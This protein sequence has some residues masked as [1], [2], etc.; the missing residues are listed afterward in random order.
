[1]KEEMKVL[2]YEKKLRVEGLTGPDEEAELS[3]IKQEQMESD[4]MKKR[5]NL[6]DFEAQVER[7]DKTLN[8]A[9]ISLSRIAYQV[10]KENKQTSEVRR[11]KVGEC[12]SACGMKLERFLTIIVKKKKNF[13]VES[14]NTNADIEAPPEYLGLNFR[15]YI[16]KDRI[17]SEPESNE[18]SKEIKL[19]DW[20]EERRTEVKTKSFV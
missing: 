5:A 14:I 7:M 8:K 11:E 9:L 13:W 19:D 3:D 4:L 2:T 6:L 15:S 10:F 12:L 20:L 1:M 18:D 17:E 16:D